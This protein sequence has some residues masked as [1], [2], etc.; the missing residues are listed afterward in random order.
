MLKI[1]HIHTDLKFLNETER[2]TKFS[3]LNTVIMIGENISISRAYSFQPIILSSHKTDLRKVVTICSS[4][5][6]V[7][8]YELDSVKSYIALKIPQNIAITWRFFGAELYNKNLVNYLSDKSL[9]FYNPKKEKLLKIFSYK[10]IYYK[11]ISIIK[12]ISYPAKNF[13]DAIN[14]VDL[15][16]CRSKY[17]YDHLVQYWKN[18]PL[19]VQIPLS[20]QGSKRDVCSKKNLVIIGNSRSIYNNH[21]DVIELIENSHYNNQLSFLIPFSYGME[22]YYTNEV[23]RLVNISQKNIVLLENFM[24]YESY[25]DFVGGAKAAVFNCHR[26]MAMGNIFEF[27]N[28]GVKIYLS[29]QNVIYHWLKDMGLKIFTIEEFTSDL[30]S[31]NLELSSEDKEI[32]ISTLIN[33][34]SHFSEEQFVIDINTFVK[35]KN[36][37]IGS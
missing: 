26:Q 15:F 30:E 20:F 23:K 3:F 24:P 32:N 36:V 19:F 5:D 13:A 25:F 18:L 2:F 10:S 1:V 12:N 22:N 31:D 8:L 17:E 35:N 34:S 4:A 29:K 27:I 7:V 21:I 11:L 9:K 16:L 6:M 37:L 33:I 14:R 28:S